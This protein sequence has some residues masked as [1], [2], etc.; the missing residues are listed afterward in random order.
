[1]PS[2]IRHQVFVS[3]TYTDLKEERAEVLQAIWEL[4]CIPTGMEAFVASNESQWDV[5]K[6][7]IEECDYYVLIVGGRYGSVTDEGISYTEKEYH[8]AKQLGIPVLAFVHSDPSAIP[9]GKTDTNLELRPKLE[10][11]RTMVMAEHPVRNWS[12]AAELGGVVSRSLVR[13]VKV[14]PR[15]GWIRN[16]G[17]S[18]LELLEQV[19]SLTEENRSL[20]EAAAAGNSEIDE[21]LEHGSDRV[22]LRGTRTHFDKRTYRT[23]RDQEWSTLTTWDDIFRDLGPT[24]FGEAEETQMKKVLARFNVLDESYEELGV[25]G[26]RLAPECWNAVL[27]QLRALGLIEQGVKKRGVNDNGRY[28][29]ITSKG[30]RHLVNLLARR[31]PTPVNL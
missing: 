23:C 8:Y 30:D 24:L 18:A 9:V 16:D 10:A 13:E 25:Q 7:V 2:S 15:P 22:E 12:N 31:R 27:I 6:K 28:W 4:D 17:P 5:I 3:S 29:T 14:S 20:R 11:F 21:T 19:R 1:M 26:E